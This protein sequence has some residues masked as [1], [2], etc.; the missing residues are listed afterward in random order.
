MV[1]YGRQLAGS[2]DTKISALISRETKELL[3][4]FVRAR[5]LKKGFVIERALQHHIRALEEIPEEFIIPP[6]IVLT[7]ESFNEIIEMMKSTPKPTPG[8]RRLM[9][10]KPVSEAGLY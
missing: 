7:G 9:K 4:R 8:L 6:E 5:G 10:G 3:E 1:G 2:K